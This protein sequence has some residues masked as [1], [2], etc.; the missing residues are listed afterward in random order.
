MWDII[1]SLDA[2]ILADRAAKG[3]GRGR[4][5]QLK[6]KKAQYS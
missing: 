3:V 1:D 4:E 6:G 2:N 5:Y